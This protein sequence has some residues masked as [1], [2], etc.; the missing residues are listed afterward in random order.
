MLLLLFVKAL[1]SATMLGLF[2]LSR[3]DNAKLLMIAYLK[4]LNSTIILILA[5]AKYAE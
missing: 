2:E 4:L 5:K 3:F 1:R